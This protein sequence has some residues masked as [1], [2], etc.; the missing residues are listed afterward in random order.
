MM[1]MEQGV[2]AHLDAFEVHVSPLRAQHTALISPRP[3][4]FAPCMHRSALPP[5]LQAAQ[6]LCEKRLQ[7]SHST[8]PEMLMPD[9]SMC[10]PMDIEECHLVHDAL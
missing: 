9:N 10:K 7:R 5:F 3:H 1:L 2:R 8:S 6:V 4:I